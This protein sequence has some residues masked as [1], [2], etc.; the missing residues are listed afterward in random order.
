MKLIYWIKFDAEHAP[1]KIVVEHQEELLRLVRELSLRFGQTF[2][3][4]I[5]DYK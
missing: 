4:I 1:R 3:W 5:R 2:E